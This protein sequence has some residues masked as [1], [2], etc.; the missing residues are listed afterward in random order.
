MEILAS[1]KFSNS[2]SIDTFFSKFN[3][4]LENQKLAEQTARFLKV[5]LRHPEPETINKITDKVENGYSFT[6]SGA[7]RT[8]TVVFE[9]KNDIL[10]LKELF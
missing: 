10:V 4:F 2:V 5:L 9:I 1:D 7:C 8:Y 3:E 6:V